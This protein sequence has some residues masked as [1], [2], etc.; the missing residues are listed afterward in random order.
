M[1]E[2]NSKLL[3]DTE[4]KAVFK[5]KNNGEL[6][7]VK[8]LDYNLK[9]LNDVLEFLVEKNVCLFY[10]WGDNFERWPNLKEFFGEFP[11]LGSNEFA[12]NE[13]VLT[14]SIIYDKET[15]AIDLKFL[16]IISIDKNIHN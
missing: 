3:E 2:I 9:I 13:L 5:I 1:P 16:I 8:H 10:K 15:E 6:W 12:D 14:Y 4:F 11:G 7:F